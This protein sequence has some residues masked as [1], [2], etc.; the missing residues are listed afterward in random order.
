MERIL[1]SPGKS[2]LS[3]RRPIRKLSFL[4]RVALLAKQ[5]EFAFPAMFA[6]NAWN[7]RWLMMSD[8]VFGADYQ[9]ANVVALSA[10]LPKGFP[11]RFSAPRRTLGR[12]F[13]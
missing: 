13:S 5:S 8:S 2:A 4:R 12:F 7:T 10:V 11:K 1:N 3:V 6:R 9:S